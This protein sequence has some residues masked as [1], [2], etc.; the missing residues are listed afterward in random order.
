MNTQP[1]TKKKLSRREEVRQRQSRTSRIAA[2]LVIGGL[3]LVTAVILYSISQNPAS[4]PSVALTGLEQFT[5]EQGHKE[6]E[7]TYAQTPPVGG[8][9]N[10]AWQNCGLYEQQIRNENGVHS[11][12]HGAVWITYKPGLAVAELDK[13]KNLTKQSGYRLLSPYSGLPS[14]IVIS[15]WGYQLKL[16]SADDPRLMSF[17]K[18]YEQNPAGPEPGA[19]CTGGVG[20]PG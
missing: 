20:E 6:G 13:L 9:H 2:I 16:E 1:E 8:A 12:E 19:P 11:L 3:L 15:A 4:P 14:P 5:V 18:K 7:L 17:I 10:S